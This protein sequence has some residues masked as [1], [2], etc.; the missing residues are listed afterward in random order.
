MSK[1]PA[2]LGC[3]FTLAVNIFSLKLWWQLGWAG[4]QQSHITGEILCGGFPV[5]GPVSNDLGEVIKSELESKTSHCCVTAKVL[6]SH[7]SI[8]VKIRAVC[9]SIPE[10][11]IGC[12]FQ[13]VIWNW[14]INTQCSLSTI[15]RFLA[16]PQ[17]YWVYIK[18]MT[19]LAKW[20]D[21]RFSILKVL[22][23]TPHRFVRFSYT[24]K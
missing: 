8:W 12:Y 10:L 4:Y 15:T 6:S 13:I 3:Y 22:A 21:H 24:D 18:I 2:F 7:K 20:N 23:T 17:A 9:T 14:T 5:Q 19:C 1:P 16:Q 11:V